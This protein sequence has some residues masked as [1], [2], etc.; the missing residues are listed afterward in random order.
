MKFPIF[1]GLPGFQCHEITLVTAGNLESSCRFVRR[2]RKGAAAVEFALIAP[3]FFLMVFGMIEFGRAIMVEQVITNAAREGARL[4]VLDGSTATNV[5]TQV[6]SYLSS[7]S[8]SGATITLNPTDPSTAAYGDPVTVTVSIPFT[9]VSWL[10]T[11][12][13]LSGKTLTASAVMR[14]ETVQ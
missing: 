10:P 2:N 11:P 9:S 6:T 7:A 3:V 1:S 8:I 13:F 4:A 12:W 14:R 5:R